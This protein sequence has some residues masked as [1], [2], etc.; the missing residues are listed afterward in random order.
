M[1][2]AVTAAA[3]A[4]GVARST[5]YRER[6]ANPEFADALRE[7]SESCVEQVETTLYRRATSGEDTTATI[8]FL[9]ARKPE[10]YAD[11]LRAD[12]VE[13]IRAQARQQVLAELQAG[14]R[15][16]APGARKLLMAAL[17]AA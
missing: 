12:Q 13:Q 16:L 14:F 11:R 9:K 6:D 4:V 17:P 8:F 7:A 15:E 2:G 5:V 3:K 10:V 1:H